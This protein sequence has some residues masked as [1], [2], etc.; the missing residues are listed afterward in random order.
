MSLAPLLEASLSIRIHAFAALVAFVLGGV[1]LLA[2]KGTWPHRA[3]GWGWVGLMALV[4]GSSLFIRSGWPL[5]GPFGPIHLL[6]VWVL[7]VLPR[8]VLAARRHQVGRHR[9]TMIHLFAGA[10]V[11]AGAFTFWPGRIMHAVVFGP[12]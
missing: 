2:P 6:S 4:A 11:I 1:Q 5:I 12:G 8:A 7:L 10:L 3:L 9:A